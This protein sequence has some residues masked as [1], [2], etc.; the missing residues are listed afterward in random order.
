MT[1][2]DNSGVLVY[3]SYEEACKA[4]NLPLPKRIECDSS[5][6]D[7]QE[8]EVLKEYFLN[9]CTDLTLYSEL[10]TIQESLDVLHKFNPL[11]FSHIQKAYLEKLCLSIACLLDQ[12]E[13]GKNKNLSLARII[14]QCDCPN[15]DAKFQELKELYAST[16]IKEWRRK[17]LAHNDLQTLMG[18]K[19]LNLKFEHDDIENIMELIQE[20]IDDISDPKVSTDIKVVLPRDQ[21]SSAFI[22]KLQCA[23]KNE[24]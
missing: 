12:A 15:L 18:T 7:Q 21:D 13:T 14:K 5:K 6:V 22:Y 17:L 24:G 19:P 8:F 20:I 2:N 4:N 1:S 23:L 10:F 11:V 9:L 3:A 16:G